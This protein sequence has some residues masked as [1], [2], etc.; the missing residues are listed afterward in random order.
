MSNT[1]TQTDAVL[2]IVEELIDLKKL[3]VYNDDI[4]TFDD[5]IEALVDVC[6][7]SPEQAE[8]CSYIIH[9]KGKTSVREGVYEEL[10]PMKAGLV[11]RGLSVV[12]E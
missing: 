1:Y 10:R 7:H 8:Q 6:D 9:Y 11:D 2:D 12:I 4:N 5:V 3:V